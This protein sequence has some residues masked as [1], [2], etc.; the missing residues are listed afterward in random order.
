M[1]E[2]YIA[3]GDKFLL[4]SDGLYS[5]FS[6]RELFDYMRKY[7]PK[8]L[9]EKLRDIAN[10]RGGEDNLTAVAVEI[11]DAPLYSTLL[12]HF[13]SFTFRRLI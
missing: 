1:Y 2:G 11:T 13:Q 4:A 3:K 9:L 7:E 8:P 10:E 12:A 5:Y 6:F